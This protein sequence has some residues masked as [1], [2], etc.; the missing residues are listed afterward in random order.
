[1]QASDSFR[2]KDRACR[3]RNGYPMLSRKK[4]MLFVN[5]LRII[6]KYPA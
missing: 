2:L 3:L 6:A 1:M 5:H 4:Y